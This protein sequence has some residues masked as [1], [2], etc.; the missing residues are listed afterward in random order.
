M[1]LNVRAAALAAAVLWGAA[2]FITGM[3]NLIR[4]GYGSLFL[5]MMASIYPGYKASPSIGSVLVGTL[6]ALLDGAVCGLVF[7]WLYNR[8]IAVKPN[9]I[10]QKGRKIA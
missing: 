1:R 10:A 5:Q 8:I 3:A 4:P 6:Y 9:I 7:A 2:L